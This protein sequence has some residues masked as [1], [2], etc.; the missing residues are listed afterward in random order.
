MSLL[1]KIAPDFTLFDGSRKPVTL[2]SYRGKRVVIA[3][4]PASFTGVCEK[5]L[6]KFRDSTASLN[7]LNACVIGVSVDSPF[8]NAAFSRKNEFGFPLLSDYTRKTVN[9]YGVAHEN[10]VDLPGYTAAKRSVFVV[11][12]DGYVAYEW[13]APVPSDEPDYEEISRFLE[14]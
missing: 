6:C 12:A 2:S 14:K 11:N 9:D 3:F 7:E 8:S 5:E 4:I 1:G 13:V 10:F